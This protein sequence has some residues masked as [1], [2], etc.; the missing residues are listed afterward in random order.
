M[1]KLLHEI[2]YITVGLA[3]IIAMF[4]I[5]VCIVP[6]AEVLLGVE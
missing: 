3:A 4:F 1:K 5:I 2:V 6:C